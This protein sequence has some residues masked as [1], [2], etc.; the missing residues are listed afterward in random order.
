M[1][2]AFPALLFGLMTFLVFRFGLLEAACRNLVHTTRSEAWFGAALAGGCST[3]CAIGAAG[4][5]FWF[6]LNWRA[7][8]RAL[9]P[10]ARVVEWLKANP[11]ARTAFV[12][13]HEINGD[14]C[15]E[16]TLKVAGVSRENVIE[17]NNSDF[18]DFLCA[19][20][21]YAKEN[22]LPFK[23][24][25][26]RAGLFAKNP[27]ERVKKWMDDSVYDWL[28]ADQSRRRAYV[29]PHGE[30]CLDVFLQVDVESNGKEGSI[31][32]GIVLRTD[33]YSRFVA[34][35]RIRAANERLRFEESEL[36]QF[37]GAVEI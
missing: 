11:G 20:Q 32:E 2:L 30:G 18:P 21:R 23:E 1:R 33:Q 14:G 13:V 7:H 29:L 36:K 8:C 10:D 5:L 35:L 37:F 3:L 16:M 4:S 19:V 26:M 22:G 25:E 12:E 9:A 27:W 15:L 24:A 17:M 28:K 34:E 6:A 31:Q